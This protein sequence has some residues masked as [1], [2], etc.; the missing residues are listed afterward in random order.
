M[1]ILGEEDCL[2]GEFIKDEEVLMFNLAS[3][4][5]WVKVKMFMTLKSYLIEAELDLR[6]V[7]AFS[8]GHCR[9]R[10]LG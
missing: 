7:G 9:R 5:I 1:P 3:T 10:H 4:E 6:Q 8:D 2:V